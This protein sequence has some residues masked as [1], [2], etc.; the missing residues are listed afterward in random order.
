MDAHVLRCGAS[1]RN[2]LPA[3]ESLWLTM[4]REAVGVC[5]HRLYKGPGPRVRPGNA[6]AGGG[7]RA[8]AAEQRIG[9][10]SSKRAPTT[11]LPANGPYDF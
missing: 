10:V 11:S 6:R 3:L 4:T 9:N 1:S 7:C 8:S 5:A 2:P